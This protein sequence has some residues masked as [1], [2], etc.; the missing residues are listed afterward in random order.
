MA[1]LLRKIDRLRFDLVDNTT[2]FLSSGT[3]SY[4][5]IKWFVGD[6]DIEEHSHTK[7]N[8]RRL[9][10]NNR[11]K[12]AS[13]AGERV[14][15]T[16][17]LH[18]SITPTLRLPRF[19]VNSYRRYSR[20]ALAS[21]VVLLSLVTSSSSRADTAIADFQA[22]QKKLEAARANH[23]S[24]GS[25]AGAKD[26]VELLKGAPD[27]ILELARA[28]VHTGDFA[29]AF[30]DLETFVR[31]GQSTGLLTASPEFAPLRKQTEFAK[32]Q[33]GMAKNRV[34]IS[35]ARTALH[36]SDPALLPEDLDYDAN[37]KRF[38]ITTV[39]GKKIISVDLDGA[40]SEFAKAPDEW[41]LLAIK[42][43]PKRNLIWA[44]EVALQGFVF[45]PESDWGRSA[46]LCYD[47]RTG[48]LLHRI[49]GPQG[50]A[51]GDMALAPN[52]DVIVSDGDGGGVYRLEASGGVLERLDAGDFISPQTPA[53]C[54][55]TKKIFV[56]D[57]V[58]GIG[59]LDVSNKTV[60]WL[61][62][63]DRFAI[64]GVDGLYIKDRNLVA[65]QNGTSPERVIAFQLDTALTKIIDETIIERSTETLGDPTHGVFVA[66]DFYYIANSGWDII[67]DHGK[68]KPGARPSVALIMRVSLDALGER[69]GDW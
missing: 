44:T 59:I 38:F 58:R 3:V 66:N 42:I 41:P 53:I 5:C 65:V 61:G 55:D 39:R 51:L 6:S 64:N 18:Y 56:P 10:L 11:G 30:D 27:A 67:D 28:K 16:P 20:T 52:G 22:I 8:A 50:S 69:H 19:S 54:P 33:D 2:D 7:W 24:S 48:K 4:Q 36:L 1:S 46:L 60:R 63:E 43:D 40:I 47:L 68:L 21:L 13:G 29:G 23:D 32:V 17:S 25:V 57:Y 26:L 14:P 45:V 37:T 12:T 62:T 9:R 15:I 31:M 35:L 49:E 34:A